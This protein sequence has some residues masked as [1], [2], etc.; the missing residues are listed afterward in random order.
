[1][2]VSLSI[3]SETTRLD[4]LSG[5][6]KALARNKQELEL[7]SHDLEN[8]QQH[9]EEREEIIAVYCTCSKI[10][11]TQRRSRRRSD[12]LFSGSMKKTNAW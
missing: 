10:D 5:L 7:L 11:S 2:K 4:R 8:L 3:P 12:D 9:I 1:M 6:V